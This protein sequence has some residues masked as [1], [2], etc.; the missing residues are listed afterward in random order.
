MDY[1]IHLGLAVRR[2]L[3]LKESPSFAQTRVDLSGTETGQGAEIS[4]SKLLQPALQSLCLAIALAAKRVNEEHT[5]GM[6]NALFD[7]SVAEAE[8]SDGEGLRVAVIGA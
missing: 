8:R 7:Q 4:H 3:V 2:E 6:Q 5:V 1:S